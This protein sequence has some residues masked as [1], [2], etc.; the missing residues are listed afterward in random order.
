MNGQSWMRWSIGLRITA[1]GL[2]M[3][4]GAARIVAL[5]RLDREKFESPWDQAAREEL[6][7]KDTKTP[8]ES[9]EA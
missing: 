6:A 8:A 3:A 7:K 9:P 5:H 1:L 4:G 2:A